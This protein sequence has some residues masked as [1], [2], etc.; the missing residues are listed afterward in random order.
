[1]VRV[2]N[3]IHVLSPITKLKFEVDVRAGKDSARICYE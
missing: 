1:M 3:K 2:E